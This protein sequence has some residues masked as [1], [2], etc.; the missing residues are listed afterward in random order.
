MMPFS[1]PEFS[2][3]RRAFLARYAGSLGGLA[4]AHLLASEQGRAAE[5]GL[6]A[7]KQ[8]HHPPRARA[9]IC[10]FQHGGPSQVDLFDP[11]PELSKRHAQPYTGE[12]EAHVHEQVGKVLGSPFKFQRAGQSGMELSE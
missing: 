5:P 1:Q 8:P 4:L 6:L 12:S 11:K 3:T 9:V 10:L 7:P 2:V